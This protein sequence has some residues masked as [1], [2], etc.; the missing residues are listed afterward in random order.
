M[1]VGGATDS[2]GYGTIDGV[3]TAASGMLSG[4][5]VVLNGITYTITGLI[6]ADVDTIAGNE[7]LFLA[8]ED[9]AGDAVEFS[10]GAGLVLQLGS[11]EFAFRSGGSG[12]A[13]FDFNSGL[14]AYLWNNVSPYYTWSNGQMVS[15]KLCVK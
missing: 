3:Y 14:S 9:T 8:F 1:T 2:T 5:E 13:T 12:F 7:A 6:A 10:S 4:D 11:R 15:V